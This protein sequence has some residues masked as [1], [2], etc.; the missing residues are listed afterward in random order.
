MTTGASEQAIQQY[1]LDYGFKFSTCSETTLSAE[2]YLPRIAELI[3][4][5]GTSAAKLP[6]PLNYHGHHNQAYVHGWQSDAN[7]HHATTEN[8][9][10]ADGEM[11]SLPDEEEHEAIAQ[12]T[13]VADPHVARSERNVNMETTWMCQV[14]VAGNEE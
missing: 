11:G 5:A 12:S 6:T 9:E 3:Y 8:E 2:W 4:A 14:L 10:V 7:R 13:K 1:L